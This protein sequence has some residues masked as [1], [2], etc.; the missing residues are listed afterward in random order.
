MQKQLR[1]AGIAIATA[2]AVTLTGCTTEAGPFV[3]NVSSDGKGDIL[4]E[5]N[6]VVV[7]SFTGTVTTGFHPTQELIRV[8]PEPQ[9]QS[10]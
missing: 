1:I 8:V 9:S 2:V 6:T 7:N 5:K 10:K 4:M 3:T